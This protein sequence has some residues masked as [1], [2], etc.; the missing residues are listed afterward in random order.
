MTGETQVG[1]ETLIKYLDNYLHFSKKIFIYRQSSH[2][3]IFS[4]FPQYVTN[5][6]I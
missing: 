2:T 1:V 3:R 5:F 6:S 4:Q